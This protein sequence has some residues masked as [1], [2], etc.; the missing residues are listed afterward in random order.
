MQHNPESLK[1]QEIK[2]LSCKHYP[3]ILI[4]GWTRTCTRISAGFGFLIKRR[5]II[6]YANNEKSV[7]VLPVELPQV[8]YVFDFLT[9]LCWPSVPVQPD[10]V[11][12]CQPTDLSFPESPTSFIVRLKKKKKV[13]P[14]NK[15]MRKRERVIEKMGWEQMWARMGVKAVSEPQAVAA[16]RRTFSPPTL[17]RVARGLSLKRNAELRPQWLFCFLTCR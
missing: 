7:I 3:D 14:C 2:A 9:R 16:S 17:A 5:L 15:P 1:F 11:Q 13:S 6:S 8:F 12:T 4:F 10:P